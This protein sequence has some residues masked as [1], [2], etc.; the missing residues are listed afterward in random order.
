LAKRAEPTDKFVGQNIRLFRKAKGFSQTQLGDAIGV[1]FQQVQKYENGFNRVGSSRLARIATALDVPVQSFFAGIMP[2]HGKPGPAESVG[3]MLGGPY[4]L[5]M[6]KALSDIPNAKIRRA[7][8]A[9][10][11]SI[12]TQKEKGSERRR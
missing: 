12:A 6:L 7:L 11:E 5:D 9:L 8:V 10:A 2:Q 3:D 1:T 4:A